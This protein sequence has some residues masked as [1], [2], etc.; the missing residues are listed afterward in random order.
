MTE[1]EKI[2][3]AKMY[4]DKLA[5]GIDPLTEHN[6][7]EVD[8]VNNVRI[9]RCLFYVSDI[10]R[11]VIENDGV[12]GKASKSK[13]PSKQ[14]FAITA[15]ELREF[16]FSEKP[17]PVSEITR[18]INDLIDPDAMVKLKHTSITALLLQAGF[19]T[20][21]ETSNGRTVKTPTAQGESIGISVEEREGPNGRYWTVV[22]NS[23]AQHF[24]LDNIDGIIAQNGLGADQKAEKRKSAEKQG[25]A[26][27]QNYDETLID[28]FKK[29]VP[30]SEIAVTLKRSEGGVRARL[31]RLGLIEKR[32]DAI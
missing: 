24:I 30:I 4:L 32:G 18:R 5:N 11:R 16:S 3:R 28:L 19:L 23:D 20:L 13:K 25:E 31:K 15:Q 14:P 7:P 17:I 29:D 12:I 9:S 27:T 22:Y 8:L 21:M 10:L 1:L 2:Q 26:W 6:V